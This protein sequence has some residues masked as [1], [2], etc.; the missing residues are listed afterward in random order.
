MSENASVNEK[1]CAARAKRMN[2]VPPASRRLIAACWAKKAPPRQ[3]IKSFCQECVG[4]DRS[5]VTECTAYA[6][7][8]WNFRPYQKPKKIRRE[9]SD[10]AKGKPT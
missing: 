4:Y 6:C 8:L 5:A 7:P 9:E 2:Y 10:E 1:I 3:A